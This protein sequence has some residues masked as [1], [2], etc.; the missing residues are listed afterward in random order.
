M[1]KKIGFTE[2]DQKKKK[3]TVSCQKSI[4]DER[5][6]RRMAKLVKVARKVT[7]A[8]IDTLYNGSIEKSIS[9]EHLHTKPWSRWLQQENT[10]LGINPIR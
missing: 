8:P 5:C 9:E 3:I 2:N 1:D 10:T 6:Q 4:T 7:V